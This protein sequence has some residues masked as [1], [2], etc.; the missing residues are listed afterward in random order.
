MAE[1]TREEKIPKGAVFVVSIGEF[2]D[3]EVLACCRAL[4]EIDPAE[5]RRN[6][7]D[8]RR[9]AAY[10]ESLEAFAW[11]EAQGYF[12]RLPWRELNLGKE[13]SLASV[14]KLDECSDT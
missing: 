7:N 3:Y 6:L 2:D 14:T 8:A 10:S 5:L 12:E 13:Y 9:Q 11:C 4:R 1:K